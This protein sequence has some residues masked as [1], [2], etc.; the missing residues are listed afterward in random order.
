[1]VLITKGCQPAVD[2]QNRFGRLWEPRVTPEAIRADL[3]ESLERLQTDCVDV[4]LLHRDD[5]AAPVVT[6]VGPT[7]VEHLNSALEAV[8]VELTPAEIDF[9]D[10]TTA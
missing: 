9:L 5:E 1:M 2:F 3:S 6:L 10:L 7:T 4:Y 8:Q